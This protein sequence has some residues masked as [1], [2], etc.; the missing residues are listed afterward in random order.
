MATIRVTVADIATKG[1]PRA[2]TP[3]FLKHSKSGGYIDK[4]SYSAAFSAYR[5]KFVGDRIPKT[6]QGDDIVVIHFDSEKQK[7]I[8]ERWQ[9]KTT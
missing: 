2:L 8:L 6:V 1:D 4:V 3:C 7:D 5:A 9:T